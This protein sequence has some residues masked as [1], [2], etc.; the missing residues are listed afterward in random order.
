ML[1]T[2][3]TSDFP[4]LRIGESVPSGTYSLVTQERRRLPACR[5]YATKDIVF[6]QDVSRTVPSPSVRTDF[7]ARG[8]ARKTWTP[9]DISDLR[10]S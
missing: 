7:S 3:F 2:L 6:S 4:G 5:R 1:Y 8:T 9:P 10:F